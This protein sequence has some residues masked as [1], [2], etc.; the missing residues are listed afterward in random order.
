MSKKRKT[1]KQ[2]EQAKQRHTEF[3]QHIHV[4]PPT[5]SLPGITPPK[6][7]KK[8]AKPVDA[9]RQKN[10][11][12][13]MKKDIVSIASASGIIIAFD[14]LLLVLLSSGTVKLNFLGY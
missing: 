11:A 4:D 9:D 7:V 14:I 8:E 10:V 5:Y 1:R 12:V 13:F 6:T 3:I 2:K